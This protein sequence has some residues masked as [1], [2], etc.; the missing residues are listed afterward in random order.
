MF[1]KFK[2]TFYNLFCRY[3]DK[4]TFHLVFRD[5]KTGK[6]REASFIKS[7]ANFIDVNGVICQDIIEPE[8]IKLHN[9]LLSDR[10]EK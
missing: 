5:G 10:K 2:N 9:S 3:D 1:L 7:V 6:R 4:Y 8:I